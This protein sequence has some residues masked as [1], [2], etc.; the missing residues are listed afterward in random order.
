MDPLGGSAGGPVTLDLSVCESSLAAASAALKEDSTRRQEHVI[1]AANGSQD[2]GG[3]VYNSVVPSFEA[4]RL[5]EMPCSILMEH[6][7]AMLEDF[8]KYQD[9]LSGIR[10]LFQFRI[11]VLEHGS[12]VCLQG[13]VLQNCSNWQVA[14]VFTLNTNNPTVSAN[15]RNVESRGTGTHAHRVL[16]NFVE[17]SWAFPASSSSSSLISSDDDVPDLVPGPDWGNPPPVNVR[18]G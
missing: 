11:P 2:S 14:N 18:G 6:G 16:E 5:S 3:I 17:V 13:G 1:K 10:P 15:L 8:V 7:R 12:W 4:L 9:C